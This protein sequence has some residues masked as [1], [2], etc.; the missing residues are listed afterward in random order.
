MSD[1]RILLAEYLWDSVTAEQDAPAL[2][3]TQKEELR[4]CLAAADVAR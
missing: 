4:C 1:E 2:T 3:A